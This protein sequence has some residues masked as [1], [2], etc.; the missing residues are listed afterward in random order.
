MPY[1]SNPFAPKARKKATNLV[2]R[3]E[4]RAEVARQYGVHR[5][6]VGRWM[7]RASTHSLEFIE[8]RSSAPKHQATAL[9]QEI[10]DRIIQIR[11]SRNRC[12][13]IV[14]AQ[15]KTEGY[16]VS[17]SSVKRVIKRHGLTRKG[18]RGQM[19]QTRFRRPPSTHPGALVQMDTIHF[20]SNRYRRFYIYAMIDTFSRLAYAEFQPMLSPTVTIDF[21][22]RAL[23]KFPFSVEVIQ[24]DHGQEFSFSVE[25]ML[26]RQDIRLRHSRVKKPNDNAHIE[27]FNRTL[28]EEC[29]DGVFPKLRTIRSQ[30]RTY[31]KYYNTQRNH[32][33]IQGKIPIQKIPIQMLQ[34]C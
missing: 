16:S 8:T 22:S 29:F 30:L 28:Q 5:S 7:K 2:K 4:K 20:V 19:T 6:T 33:G 24:T 34:S 12:A 1:T 9:S 3:G 21:L 32:L 31:M 27:R 26:R 11:K 10:V 18:K 17:L 15:M 25:V 14:H 13:V 23:K